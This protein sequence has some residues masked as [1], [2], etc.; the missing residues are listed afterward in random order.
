MPPKIYSKEPWE[1]NKGKKI[2]NKSTNKNKIP[3]NTECWEKEP[4]EHWNVWLRASPIAHTIIF[5]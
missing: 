1:I 5:I 2:K 4:Y 3:Q